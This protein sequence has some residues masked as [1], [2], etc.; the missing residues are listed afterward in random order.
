M[1]DNASY[2]NFAAPSPFQG[3]GRQENSYPLVADLHILG[4]LADVT[5]HRGSTGHASGCAVD[6]PA[7]G[8]A[9]ERVRVVLLKALSASPHRISGRPIIPDYVN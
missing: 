4:R 3:N 9:F 1:S 5:F 8:I 6:L 2:G 7:A